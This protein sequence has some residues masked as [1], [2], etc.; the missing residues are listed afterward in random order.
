MPNG[1]ATASI[2]ASI[3]LSLKTAM[4]TYL[5]IMTSLKQLSGEAEIPGWDKLEQTGL[6]ITVE[7]D[8]MIERLKAIPV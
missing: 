8:A 5:Q 6:E 1:V 4:E 3:L 7:L 2:I